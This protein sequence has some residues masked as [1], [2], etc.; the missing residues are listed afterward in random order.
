[1][2]GKTISHYDI[3]QKLGAGGMG[4]IYKAVDSRLNR[5]VA[6]KVLPAG[7]VDAPDRR[8][9]FIQ[10]AQAA[11]ALNHP[12]IITIYDIVSEQETEYMV[13]EFVDG[14]T[15]DQA[16]P[17][18]GLELEKTLDYA[19]AD[20]RRFEGRPC[21]RDCS[22]RPQTGQH[23]GDQFRAHQGPRLRIGQSRCAVHRVQ[24]TTMTTE[25]SILGTVNYMSPEQAQGKRVDARS[26][27]FSFGLVLYEM[28][29]GQR[30]FDG[31]SQ[32]SILAT[33]LRDPVTSVSKSNRGLPPGFGPDH[34]RKRSRRIRTSAGRIWRS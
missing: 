11:S 3:R 26:D 16:I 34:C 5:T 25:G 21:R 7:S 29:T 14:Q 20:H 6:I 10:E 19:S 30:A 27:I 22:S 33:I 31:D 32:L 15:L 4:E 28:V 12:N 23:Y 18:N 1:M 13:M 24:A 8:R 9:R 17:P 2:I